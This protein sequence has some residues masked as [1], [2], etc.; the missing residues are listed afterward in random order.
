MNKTAAIVQSSYIPWKGYFDV[1]A[2][3]DEFIFYD[4]VQFTRRDWRN[5]NKIKTSQ[6]LQWLT[7][8]VRV[9]GKYHQR[10]IDTVVSDPNW[11]RKHWASLRHSYSRAP[12]FARYAEIFERLYLTNDDSHLSRINW[13]FITEICG[14]L[15]IDTILSWSTDYHLCEGT[16]QRLVDL[17]RQTGATDYLSGP[18]ARSYLTAESFQLAGIGLHFIDY[19]EYPEYRQLYPPFE[20]AVSILDL[21]FN[22]G[23]NA[24]KYMKSF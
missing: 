10:I 15:G 6:G 24:T 22:E 3:A 11:G 13:R 16:T 4:D 18:S 2:L 14:I 1:I 7:I 23:P 19:S 8:P 17:C 21:I 12:Y 20:H 5:R 9:K